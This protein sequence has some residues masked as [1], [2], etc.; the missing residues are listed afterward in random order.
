M[1]RAPEPIDPPSLHQ[2][3]RPGEEIA[4][5]IRA[6]DALLVVTTHGLT[7]IDGGRTALDV[8]FAAVRRLQ[9]DIERSRPAT[10]VV[11]P[12]HPADQP[13]V[14]PIGQDQYAAIAEALVTIGLAIA[15]PADDGG[16][17]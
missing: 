12:D 8:P 11:V 5:A 2:L 13:Q 15:S 10:L 6:G 14:L 3:V 7:V 17:A 9:F 4:H 1:S 16:A